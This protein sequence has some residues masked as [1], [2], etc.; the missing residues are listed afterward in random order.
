MEKEYELFM[1]QSFE[2]TRTKFSLELRSEFIRLYAI[3]YDY[4]T[5]CDKL[6]LSETE[7]MLISVDLN[8]YGKLPVRKNG[9]FGSKRGLSDGI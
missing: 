6:G 8:H 5:I 1:H 3:G 7:F 9:I 4:E 2:G